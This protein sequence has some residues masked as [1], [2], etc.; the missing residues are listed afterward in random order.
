M[1]ND[2]SYIFDLTGV[3]FNIDKLALIRQIGLW[4][5][6]MY[7]ITQRKNPVNRYLEALHELSQRES[8]PG[9]QLQHYGYKFPTCVSDFYRGNALGS[10]VA[11]ELTSGIEILAREGF[12]ASERE[13]DLI[14][15]ITTLAFATD[16]HTPTFKPIQ[17][18]IKLLK[19]LRA[20]PSVRLYL[21]SN[22][23]K[24][25]YHALERAYPDFFAL[26][27]GV[28]ISAIV[29]MIKPYENIYQFVFDTYNVDPRQTL[30][31]DDQPENVAAGRAMGLKAVRFTSPQQAIIA[32]REHLNS[33]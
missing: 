5:T 29:H 17:P 19:E 10:D 16:V 31:L 14:G 27:D 8:A 6:F 9:Q 28:T 1:K 33:I 22:L 30:F 11:R 23:D 15:R 32:A 13:Y 12:F 3:L 18:M 7:A 24:P 25:S 26:F 20:E 21:L 2:I 4:N